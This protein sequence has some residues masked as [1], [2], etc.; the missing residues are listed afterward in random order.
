MEF[1]SAF[2]GLIFVFNTAMSLLRQ[3]VAGI[4]PLRPDF[5]P[6][7]VHVRFVLEEVTLEVILL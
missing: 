1:N 6:R 4:T 7:S 2:K 5:N 3:S